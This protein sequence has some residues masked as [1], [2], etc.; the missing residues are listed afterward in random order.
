MI[1]L[2]DFT[3]KRLD[4]AAAAYPYYSAQTQNGLE[5][6]IEPLTFGRWYVGFYD[7]RHLMVKPKEL[8]SDMADA[9]R[10]VARYLKQSHDKIIHN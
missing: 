3:E 6:C 9:L 8:A 4:G 10:T 7:K 5:I 1:H 2:A